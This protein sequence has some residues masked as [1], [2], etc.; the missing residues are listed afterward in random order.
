MSSVG[1]WEFF[2]GTL[3]VVV[4]L[5]ILGMRWQA[6][7]DQPL[8]DLDMLLE[9]LTTSDEPSNRAECYSGILALMRRRKRPLPARYRLRL[10]TLTPERPELMIIL[11]ED[12]L[13]SGLQV[14]AL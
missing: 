1:G 5:T 2:V 10:E 4:L 6:I 13:L 7:R 3:I 11:A 14:D 9:S 12:D 8:F